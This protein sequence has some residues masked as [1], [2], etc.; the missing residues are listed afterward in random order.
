MLESFLHE[1]HRIDQISETVEEFDWTQFFR[2]R[3]ID[4]KGDEVRTA[5]SFGWANIGPALPKEIG[6]V[7]LRDLCELGCQYYVDHFPTFLKPPEEWPRL[8]RGRVMVSPSDWPE[9][10]RN[11]VKAGVCCVIPESEVFKVRGEPVLNGLFGVE[12]GEESNG[13]I[14]GGLV[15]FSTFRRQLLGSLNQ[16]WA[17]IESFNSAG[18]HRLLIPTLVKVE[19][20]RF[21]GLI[22][23]C[24]LDFRLPLRGQVTCSDASTTGGG[25]CCSTGLTAM[26]DLVSTGELRPEGSP[27]DGRPRVLSV[28]LFD[29]VG[30]LRLAL[31]LIGAQV[32]GHISVEKQEAGHRVVEYHFPGSV[33]LDDVA[34]ITED[35]VRGWSLK[36]GQVELVIL[37]GGPPC[38][39]VSGLNASRR[40][41]LRDERSS[42]YVHVA[43]IRDLLR[44]F[45]CWCPVHVLMESVASMDDE[46]RGHMSDSFGESPWSIDAG[47]M[48]WCRRPRLY[49]ITW[50]L[51]PQ[52]GVAF[53]EDGV[54]LSAEVDLKEFILQGWTK[55][56]ETRSF[57]T[58]T[59]SRPRSSPGHR[60]AGVTQCDLQTLHRWEQDRYRYPPYQYLPGNC[61]VNRSG[62]L[63]LP[64]IQ[65]KELMMGMPRGYTV[66]CVVKSQRKSEA[67]LDL[68]HTLVGNAWS[69]P[70]VAWLLGQLL[71]PLG[72]TS[73]LSPQEVMDRLDPRKVLDVR[74][75]LLRPPLNPVVSSTSGK[76]GGEQL[77]NLLGRLVSTKG[78]DILISSGVDH[79][80]KFQCLRQTV[81]P[82]LWHWKIV[83]GWQW[84]LSKEH[85]NVLELRALEATIRWR[86]ER[87]EELQ[88]RFVHLTDSLVCLHTM[89]RGRSSSRKLRR[90]VCRLNAV[91]LAA[92]VSPV[93]GYVHTDLNPADKPSRWKIRTKFRKCPK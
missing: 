35:D 45:F 26:G 33:L 90:V 12:K 85:I 9:V 70:V 37:G 48:T 66:P 59:T 78:D 40:G 34:A 82:N 5:K 36:F 76:I 41:A 30:C 27:L 72:A 67:H 2:C 49:W 91:M 25:M 32:A 6:V 69:V 79:I 24:R 38:Q 18:R 10:A 86:I 68:R 88:C 47:G 42:L 13:V 63:R 19:I 14:C 57:P 64:D 28:G 74:S 55:V 20:L 51:T 89:S 44:K 80:A 15:Y 93:F 31:D 43:R 29:G 50:D 73:L 81:P 71:G 61:L 54:S 16:C 60:P 58:F 22:P 11:L 52:K 84:S 46:D 1:I 77:A 53:E 75:K 21:V 7:P 3:T 87:R 56:D 4:Y 39:G 8:K 17:F 23:L 92:G 83:S 62:Q 65:E